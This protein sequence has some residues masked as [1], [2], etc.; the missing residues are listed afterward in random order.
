MDDDSV[1]AQPHKAEKEATFVPAR[2][3]VNSFYLD[4]DVYTNQTTVERRAVV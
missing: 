3:K 4:E 2:K 1:A